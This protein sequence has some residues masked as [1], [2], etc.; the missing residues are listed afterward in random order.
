MKNKYKMKILSI[1]SV[2]LLLISLQISAQIDTSY[3]RWEDFYV[4]TTD[5]IFIRE[6][7]TIKSKIICSIPFGEKVSLCIDIF[8]NYDTAEFKQDWRRYSGSVVVGWSLIQYGKFIG[9]AFNGYL[10]RSVISKFDES[11]SKI[12]LL[13]EGNFC[14]GKLVFN[15]V[16]YW[17]AYYLNSDENYQYGRLKPVNI[18]ITTFKTE[19]DAGNISISTNIPEESLFLIGLDKQ[20]S[21]PYSDQ[22]KK[23]FW[24]E[25]KIVYPGQSIEVCSRAVLYALGCANEFRNIHESNIKDYQ[26]YVKNADKTQNLTKDIDFSLESGLKILKWYGDINGDNSPEVIFLTFSNVDASYLFY[27]G[28]EYFNDK[29][30]V[31]RKVAK[32]GAGNCY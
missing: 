22:F 23:S 17:Y 15:P 11:N 29:N 19:D 21:K 13:F 6:K 8:E 25:S 7:P 5:G 3:C 26:L 1:S 32:F 27:M 28:S 14:I 2:F 4:G 18:K 24:S 30:S 20:I 16:L 31:M 12:Q 9:Y 10:T